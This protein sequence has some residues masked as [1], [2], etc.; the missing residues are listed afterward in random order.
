MLKFRVDRRINIHVIS[1]SL[2]LPIKI[3]FNVSFQPTFTKEGSTRNESFKLNG[4]RV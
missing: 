1:T 2:K 3:C 4:A